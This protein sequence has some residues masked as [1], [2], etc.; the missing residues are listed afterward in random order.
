MDAISFVLG[1]Q[2]AQL[3]GTAL[4]DLVYSF[5][6]AD[7]EA[8]A[9]RGAY[10]KLI[11]E[12]EEGDEVV[13]ARHI[14]AAGAGEYRVDGRVC[15]ADAYNERLK[16]FGI[17]VK[18]RNFLVFQGDI[19][20]VRHEGKGREGKFGGRAGACGRLGFFGHFAIFLQRLKEFDPRK[21]H[22]FHNQNY[23]V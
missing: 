4:K 11:Y 5:D 3:R 19:E 20:S 16:R 6:L 8:N 22:L 17:L 13:F 23:D 15:T 9:R 14:T 18:A 1:V 21:R 12:T 10:V 7:K 2:S